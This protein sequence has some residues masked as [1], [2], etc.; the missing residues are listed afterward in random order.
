MRP[1]EDQ[2]RSGGADLD[3][4]AEAQ[5]ERAV[6]AFEQLLED[7]IGRVEKQRHA[8]F[9]DPGIER[10]EPLGINT[11][12]TADAA[13]KIGAHQPELVD[14]VIEHL[15][16][17]AGVDQRH[18]GARPD[19]ARVLAL[20]ARH[21]LVPHRGDVTSFSS[22][23]RSEKA[24]E[25]RPDRADHAI[26]LMAEAVH[27]LELLVEVEPLG[28]AVDRLAELGAAPIAVATTVVGRG[29]GKILALAELLENRPRPPM[30]MRIDNMHARLLPDWYL[31]A[32]ICL[33]N[34]RD[35]GRAGQCK[36]PQR[37]NR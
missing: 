28:P 9:L 17:D 33:S 19:P 35:R 8:E 27:M 1:D 6:I 13:R 22:G 11:G 25:E 36:A 2:P 37:R 3:D 12:I 31:P 20:R 34:S 10:L 29:T 15:D 4:P 21:L 7:G 18:C 23:E 5:I 16:G 32:L 30:K 24:T 26:D 14:R